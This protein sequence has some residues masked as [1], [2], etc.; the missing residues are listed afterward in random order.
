MALPSRFRQHR[1][2]RAFD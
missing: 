2:E 1:V